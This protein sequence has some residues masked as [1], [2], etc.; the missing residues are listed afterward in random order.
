MLKL[1][2]MTSQKFYKIGPCPG[3]G[4]LLDGV[5]GLRRDLKNQVLCVVYTVDLLVRF[6]I[7]FLL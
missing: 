4:R 5:A 7:A 3:I 2:K 6:H 1:T